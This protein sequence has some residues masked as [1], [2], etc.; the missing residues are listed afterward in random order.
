VTCYGEELAQNREVTFKV[1]I[2]G[3]SQSLHPF[4]GD[5]IY[6]I[7]RA[8]ADKGTGDFPECGSEPKT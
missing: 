1:T 6:R 4:V 2:V 5:E 3:S 8:V 7:T